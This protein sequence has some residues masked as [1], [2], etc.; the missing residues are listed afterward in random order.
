MKKTKLTRSLMA[1]CS[2]VAL[3]AVMYGCVHSGGPSQSELDAEAERAAAA[4]QAAKDAEAAQAAAEQAAAA[5]QTQINGLRMQLGLEADDDLGDDIADLQAELARLQAELQARMDADDERMA[6]EASDAAKALLP[7]L[8]NSAVN[9][10]TPGTDDHTPPVPMV[11]VSNDGMLMAKVDNVA[12]YTMSGMADMIEG[13]RGAM[14]MNMEGDTAVVYSDIGNDGTLTLLD[15]YASNLPTATSARSWNIDN[16]DTNDADNADNDISWS[17]VMRPDE[18]TTAGGPSSDPI[19]MFKGTVH[20]ISGTFS[21]NADAQALCTAPVRYS[22][23]T[24]SVA[25]GA[26]DVWAFTPDEGELTYTDDPNYLIFGWWLSKGPDGKADDLTL[27]TSATG[28]GVVRAETSTAGGTLRGSATYKGAAAGK[29]AIASLSDDMY[30]GGHFTAMATLMVDFDVDSDGT[31]ANDRNGIALS[32]MIDNFMTGDMARDSWMVKLM[33]DGNNATDGTAD[34]M[35]PLSDLGSDLTDTATTLSTEWSTGGAQK[36]T[37]TWTAMFYG[38]GDNTDAAT[39][40]ALPAAAIGTFN[41]HIGTTDATDTGAV[42]R[43][44]GAFG[45]NK[46]DE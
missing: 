13:W 3:S 24:V 1:A 11:S 21:C 15:R 10:T 32:G 45:A 39:N 19:T 31:G 40:T 4:E 35:Q 18:M 8:A 28:H 38:G 6:Q 46:M 9:Q 25:S 7:V 29:Y 33:A 37:G 12:G 16:D 43:I 42:G 44:Q 17:A 5:L 23:G 34:G 2:I 27:I 14:L 22:D 41:A 36:G 20:G 30:D 26:T